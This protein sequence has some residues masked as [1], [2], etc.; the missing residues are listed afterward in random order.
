MI[1]FIYESFIYSKNQTS[2]AEAYRHCGITCF[3]FCSGMSLPI[4]FRGMLSRLRYDKGRLFNNKIRFC[5]CA[6]LSSA[7]IYYALMRNSFSCTQKIAVQIIQWLNCC[8][9]YSV[10][11]C[12]YL[13]TDNGQRMCIYRFHPWLNLSGCAIHNKIF[14]KHNKFPTNK[15]YSVLRTE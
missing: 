13:Q 4:L 12:L 3:L 8:C 7:Y 9:S 6:S 2:P 15:S 14:L 1:N 11:W 5:G 10:C